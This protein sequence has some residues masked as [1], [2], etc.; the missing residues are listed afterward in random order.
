VD[1]PHRGERI[2]SVE[3]TDEILASSDAVVIVTHHSAYD[4]HHIVDLAQVVVDTRNATRNVVRGREKV[5]VL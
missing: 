5:V 4:Y 3:L 2:R 1:D